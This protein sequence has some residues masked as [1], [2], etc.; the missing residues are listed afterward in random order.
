[1]D[2]SSFETQNYILAASVVVL[3]LGFIAA[4]FQLISM[5]KA[6]RSQAYSSL[7]SELHALDQLLIMPPTLEQLLKNQSPTGTDEIKQR[8]LV[9][10][11]LDLYESVHSRRKK[12]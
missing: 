4:M 1:M 10:W 2:W 6:I 3:L 7:T 11:H 5:R 12:V 8:W 9:F